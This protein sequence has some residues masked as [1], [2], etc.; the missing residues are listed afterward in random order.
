MVST[1]LI[2]KINIFFGLHDLLK[3]NNQVGI[4]ANNNY[5]NNGLGGLV[6]SLYSCRFGYSGFESRIVQTLATEVGCEQFSVTSQNRE[7]GGVSP[8]CLEEHIKPPCARSLTSRVKLSSHQ[9]SFVLYN[10][11]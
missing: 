8:P 1:H 10:F 9:L 5:V 7:F 11:F 6:S 2:A 3:K 4:Y